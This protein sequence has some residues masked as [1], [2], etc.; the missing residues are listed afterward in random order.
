MLH[1]SNLNIQNDTKK[2]Q[3]YNQK[4][5]R[6]KKFHVPEK[7]HQFKSESDQ[8]RCVIQIH[9]SI[10]KVNTMNNENRGL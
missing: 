7:D 10:Y 9:N 6:F 3:Q 4:A 8:E 1:L 5:H 2:F